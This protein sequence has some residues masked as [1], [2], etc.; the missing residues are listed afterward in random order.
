[1]YY[2]VKGV[3]QTHGSIMKKKDDDVTL[4]RRSAPSLSLSSRFGG[5]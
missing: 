3:L 4:E 5:I 2:S 1:M